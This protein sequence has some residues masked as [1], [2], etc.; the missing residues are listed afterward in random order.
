MIKMSGNNIYSLANFQKDHF[1]VYEHSDDLLGEYKDRWVAVQNQKIIDSD[2]ELEF[3]C[4][5]LQ[6]SGNNYI[7]YITNQP[8]EMI[9]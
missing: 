2:K 4:Q 1:W 5:R 3:L 9:L 6:N 8:L 7:E